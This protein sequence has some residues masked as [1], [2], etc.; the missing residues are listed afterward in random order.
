MDIPGYVEYS[1]CTAMQNICDLLSQYVDNLNRTLYIAAHQITEMR[2]D[3]V[4]MKTSTSDTVTS[5]LSYRETINTSIG[6]EGCNCEQWNQPKNE[7]DKAFGATSDAEKCET[8][9]TVKNTSRSTDSV[10]LPVYDDGRWFIVMD[11]RGSFFSRS[12]H[13]SET[14]STPVVQGVVLPRDNDWCGVKKIKWFSARLTWMHKPKRR[15]WKRRRMK[16][17][18]RHHF[19]N[20]FHPGR[21]NVSMAECWNGNYCELEHPYLS[22]SYGL[23]MS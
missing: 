1:P 18:I 2:S 11:L 7:T 19:V 14:C 4:A 13:R 23:V 16:Q 21:M 5:L 6:S 22:C 9:E 8:G 12:K 20:Q 10:Q 15:S 17:R 3:I